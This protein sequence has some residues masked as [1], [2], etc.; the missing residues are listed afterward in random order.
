MAFS[1]YFM[2]KYKQMLLLIALLPSCIHLAAS[3][4]YDSVV[5]GLSALSISICLDS[6]HKNAPIGKVRIAALSIIGFLFAPMKAIYIFIV[7]F[8]R[9]IPPGLF[10][11]KKSYY[12]SL[13]AILGASFFSWAARFSPMTVFATTWEDVS[14]VAE[15]VVDYVEREFYDL[16][17]ILSHLQDTIKVFFATLQEN[18][19]LYLSQMVGGEM[20]EPILSDIFI[21]EPLVV[22]ML[23]LL[24]LSVAMR[25]KETPL[26]SPFQKSISIIC[27][28]FVIAVLTYVMLSWTPRHHDTIWGLQGR[29]LLPLLP[30]ILLSLQN[31]FLTVKNDI[32]RP[33]VMA[34]TGCSLIAAV[35][36]FQEVV[37]VLG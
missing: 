36:V 5:I 8:C 14:D 24:C 12:L 31:G 28:L 10:K 13:S 7:G 25:Q 19:W 23:L 16:G 9:I 32:A 2:P 29:Y 15:P 35:N 30:L 26:L 37:G 22:V 3:F 27:M 17:Y 6:A 1:V 34:M 11:N 4:S 21:F 33:L 20:G 18:S